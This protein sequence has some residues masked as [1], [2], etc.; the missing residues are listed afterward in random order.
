MLEDTVVFGPL[1]MAIDIVRPSAMLPPLNPGDA[2]V[3]RNVGAYNLTQ[4]MQFIRLRP[5]V[6]MIH[7]GRPELIRRAETLDD[8]KGPERLP[9]WL[10]P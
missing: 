10:A 6:V 1:C 4:W 3:I 2:L 8:I 9:A 5:A 7:D